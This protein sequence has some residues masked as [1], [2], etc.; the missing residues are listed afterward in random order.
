MA[1]I[2]PG[3]AKAVLPAVISGISNAVGF[4]LF[5]FISFFFSVAKATQEIVGHFIF[6]GHFRFVKFLNNT[7]KP[8]KMN[9]RGGQNS[10]TL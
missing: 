9:C 1:S 6:I 3:I 4:L 5:Y 10:L 7:K 2:L 8:P